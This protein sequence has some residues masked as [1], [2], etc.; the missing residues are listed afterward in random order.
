MIL[1]GDQVQ[2]TPALKELLIT[3]AAAPRGLVRPGAAKQ[4]AA[5]KGCRYS[6]LQYTGGCVY[7]ITPKGRRVLARSI[8]RAAANSAHL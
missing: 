3:A 7:K 6:V 2:M 4:A 8:A 5:V 1:E